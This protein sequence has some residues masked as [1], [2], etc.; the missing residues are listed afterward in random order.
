MPYHP[1]I[2]A[3]LF[4]WDFLLNSTSK[5]T[6]HSRQEM[7]CYDDSGWSHLYIEISVMTLFATYEIGS[8]RHMTKWAD[9]IVIIFLFNRELFS[10]IVYTG[11]VI[12]KNQ[13][14]SHDQHH[15]Q[16]YLNKH[17]SFWRWLKYRINKT[18]YIILDILHIQFISNSFSIKYSDNQYISAKLLWHSLGL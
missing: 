8:Q 3:V 7:G 9:G 14:Q 11:S 18:Y 6:Q 1:H 2:F 10:S 4:F 15:I 17:F 12:S 13:K 16:K 5:L